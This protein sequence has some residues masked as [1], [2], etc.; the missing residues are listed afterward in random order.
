MKK[1]WRLALKRAVF[2]PSVSKAITGWPYPVAWV[3]WPLATSQYKRGISW[4]W[5]QRNFPKHS[6]LPI[7]LNDITT[8]DKYL[9]VCPNGNRLWGRS[10]GQSSWLQIQRSEFDSRRYQIFWEVVG[11]ERGPLGLVSTTEELLGRNSSGSGL[12]SRVSVRERTI[13]TERRRLSAK[14]VPTSEIVG[15]RVVSA[16]YPLRP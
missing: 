16:A 8:R 3:S 1:I 6:Y 4:Y 12:E 9:G 10:S 7:L 5:R 2:Y 13:K 15:C 11:L 14:L